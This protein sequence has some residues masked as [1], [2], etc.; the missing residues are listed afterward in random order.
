MKL[1]PPMQRSVLRLV[2]LLSSLAIHKT[3]AL[4]LTALFH[5][6]SQHDHSVDKTVKEASIFPVVTDAS[7]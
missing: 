2:L 7:T 6:P 5:N 4:I 3:L 1:F